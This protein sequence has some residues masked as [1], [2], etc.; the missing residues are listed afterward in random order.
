MSNS[1]LTIVFESDLDKH[2]YLSNLIRPM[3]K[4]RYEADYSFKYIESMIDW[5]D[6]DYGLNLE[7]D[8]QRGHV[9][10]LRQQ[11]RFVESVIRGTVSSA[12]L[13]IQ[14]N[15]PRWDDK[16]G[17]DLPDEIQC[18]DGLQRLTAIRKFLSGEL[19]AFGLRRE[20]FNGTRFDISRSQIRMAIFDFQ[21]KVDLLQYYLDLNSGGTV[22]STEELTRVKTMMLGVSTNSI[23]P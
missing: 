3:T 23:K 4:S 18:I 13:L 11:E 17:G 21:N 10:T 12:G 14:F 8:F 15:C 9:W 7:P 6:K 16:V 20:D 5:L 1:T 22:H 19:T 2:T